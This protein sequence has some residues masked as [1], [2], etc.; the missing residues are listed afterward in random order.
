MLTH[1]V[2]SLIIVSAILTVFALLQMFFAHASNSHGQ[3][4]LG[5]LAINVIISIYFGIYFAGGLN[6]LKQNY[7][8]QVNTKYR[9]TLMMAF[10]IMLG[11]VNLLQVPFLYLNLHFSAAIFLM[12]FC[13]AIFA[14]QLVLGK[15]IV[16]KVLIPAIPFLLLQLMKVG[17][18]FNNVLILIFA[19]CIAVIIAMYC[20]FLQKGI[21]Q[22]TYQDIG[23]RNNTLVQSTGLN[24]KWLTI[25]NHQL[26]RFI[27]SSISKSPSTIDLAVIMPHTKLAIYTIFYL[28]LMAFFVSISESKQVN[29]IQGFAPLFLASY[30]V[31]LIMETSHLIKQTKMIAHT[32]NGHQQLKSQILFAFDKAMLFNIMVFSVGV[33][34]L[35]H[36]LAI[37][38]NYSF[39]F[40]MLLVTTGIILAYS[41]LLLCFN[42]LNITF[43]LIAVAMIY[44]LSVFYAIRWFK[45][46]HD[47]GAILLFMSLLFVFC[48][49]LRALT[50]WVFWQRPFEQLLK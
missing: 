24:F 4:T 47:S 35:C 31:N 13:I 10:L 37:D 15:N 17:V 18:S 34:L 8:W 20:G 42:W 23:F 26:S 44:A 16:Y 28:I 43:S 48:L 3:A 38:I 22:K 9:N 29:L 19:N 21:N 49:L 41:P 25:I 7:L 12:P 45:D 1:S 14:S 30:A 39:L 40:L 32:F 46:F 33:Y 27:T 6:K 36:F 50:Q 5:M 2:V 11:I